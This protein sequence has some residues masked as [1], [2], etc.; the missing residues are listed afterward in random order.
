FRELFHM[1]L[2]FG[3]TTLAWIF[4]RADSISHAFSYIGRIFSKSLFEMPKFD[5]IRNGL[6]TII[7]VMIFLVIEWIGRENNYAIEKLGFQW[8]R[9][10]RWILYYLLI[11]SIFLFIGKEQQFIYFQF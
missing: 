4:F 11:L 2:T 9:P 8:K 10:M 5:G 1:I 3:L 6:I 7:L